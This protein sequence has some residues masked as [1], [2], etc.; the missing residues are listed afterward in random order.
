MLAFFLKMFW[1]IWCWLELASMTL[2]L[3]CLAW[4]PQFLRT[5]YYHYLFRVWC[6]LFVRALGVDCVFEAGV[7]V[8]HPENIRL[9]RNVYVGHQAI[10]KGY[11]RNEMVIGDETWIGQQCFFHFAPYN[12]AQFR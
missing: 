2:V 1:L 6:S 11:Y 9:G 5:G 8:F 7:L 3:Y 10:L 4:L 12:L